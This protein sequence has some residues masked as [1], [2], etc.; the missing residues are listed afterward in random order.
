MRAKD[1]ERAS[2][3]G[4][5]KALHRALHGVPRLDRHKVQLVFHGEV[6]NEAAHYHTDECHP[7][8]SAGCY[9]NRRQREEALRGKRMFKV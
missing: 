9:G 1:W 3:S 5:V 7:Q 8:A 4:S 6:A 2:R